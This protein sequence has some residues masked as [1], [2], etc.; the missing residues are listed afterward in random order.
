MTTHRSLAPYEESLLSELKG[1]VAERAAVPR[2]TPTLRYRYRNRIAIGLAAAAVLAVA[3]GVGVPALLGTGNGPAYAAERDPDGSIRIYIREYRDPKGLEARLRQ[4]GVPAVIDYVPNG[5]QCR[6][7]RA[8]YV[9]PTQHPEGLLTVM[10]PEDSDSPQ[11]AYWRLHPDK[12]GEGRT[13]VYT[14]TIVGDPGDDAWSAAGHSQLAV[15]P[16]SPCELVPGPV[17]SRNGG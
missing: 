1:V 9:P 3:A 11:G 8:T 10:D 12:I 16:V 15:G 14:T 13:F 17:F 7:P 6:E 5:K 4:L 2:Q